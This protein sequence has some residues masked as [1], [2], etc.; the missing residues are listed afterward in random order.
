MSWAEVK[1]INSDLNVPLNEGGVKIV[2]SVQR[3]ISNGSTT[4]IA[5]SEVNPDKCMLLLDGIVTTTRKIST[6]VTNEDWSA[7]GD[8][9]GGATLSSITDNTITISNVKNTYSWQLIEFY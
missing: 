4:S 6:N 5:I 2:K 8:A 3:G 9:C 1:K 7:W